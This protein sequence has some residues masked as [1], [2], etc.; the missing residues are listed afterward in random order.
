MGFERKAM[1]SA[2]RTIE[3]QLW[4]AK[5][6]GSPLALKHL[7]FFNWTFEVCKE[8]QRRGRGPLLIPCL[9]LTVKSA[10][11]DSSLPR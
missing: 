11:P 1:Y 9:D 6:K 8:G 4:C 7:L 2:G 3:N 5:P 10:L